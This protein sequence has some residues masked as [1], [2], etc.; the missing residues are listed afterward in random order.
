MRIVIIHDQVAG[1]ARKDES[2]AL[3]QARAVAAALEELGHEWTT[4]GVT[5]DL[6]LVRSALERIGPDIAFNL[7]ESIAGHGRLIHVIPGLLDAMRI[8]YTGVSAEAQFLTSNK[9]IAKQ[10]M[11]GAGIATPAWFRLDQLRNDIPLQAGRYILKSV[12]E[13]SSIGLD[14]DSI[15]QVDGQRSSGGRLGAALE[16]RLELLGGEGF[17]ERFIDGREF[18]LALLTRPRMNTPRI[19]T[20]GT[21]TENTPG[22][23]TLEPQVLPLAEIIFQGYDS[24]TPNIVGWRAKWEETSYEYHNTP[25][26]YDF[27]AQDAPLLNELSQIALQCWRVFDL[28][29]YVRVDFRVDRDNHPWVLEINTNPCLSPDAGFAAALAQANLPF[30]Q[31]IARILADA[32]RVATAWAL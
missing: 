23:I 13:H 22:T 20:P 6:D 12:W 15:V 14:E 8:P 11:R 24:S 7:V 18:N 16:D 10:I 5:L 30:P 2:D 4:L 29:G 27:P 26:R 25:R 32:R 1:S 17:A 28:H 31:A 3:V 21:I 9:L 19:N